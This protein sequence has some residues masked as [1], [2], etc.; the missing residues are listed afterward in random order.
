M[1]KILTAKEAAQRI[2]ADIKTA[3]KDNQLGDYPDGVTFSVRR[4]L[5]SLMSEINVTIK[6]APE[7]W[8]LVEVD[9]KYGQRDV[10][11]PAAKQL[12]EKLA[13]IV[14]RHYQADSRH[15]F[16]NVNLQRGEYVKTIR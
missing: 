11:T 7:E 14:H 2:R 5:A 9:D 8:A 4:E 15:R 10:P 3:A 13:A 12:A 6:G 1:T 16:V